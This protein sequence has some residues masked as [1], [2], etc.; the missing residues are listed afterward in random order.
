MSNNKQSSIEW[1]KDEISIHLNFD[2][3][4]YLRE[5]FEQAKA[6]HEEENY[7]SWCK[8]REKLIEENRSRNNGEI[9][10]CADFYKDSKNNFEEWYNETFTEKK[11]GFVD[12]LNN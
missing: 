12:R 7:Q 5:I 11:Q 8:G 3:R 4:L 9:V 6:I 1:F 2:Q 10:S